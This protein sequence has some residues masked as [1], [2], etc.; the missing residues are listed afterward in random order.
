MELR[1]RFQPE[2]ED[3]VTEISIGDTILPLRLRENPRARRMIL[4]FDRSGEGLVLTL[5]ARASRKRAIAFAQAQEAWILSRMAQKPNRL[6]FRHGAQFPYRG[7]EI[8]IHCTGQTRGTNRLDGDVLFVSGAQDHVSRRVHD[9]LKA[10]AKRELLAASAHYAGK[11]GLQFSRMSL[12][13]T[14]SRWGSCS[15]SGVIS[16]SWRLIFAPSSVLEYVCAHE[17][18]HLR[19]LN[20]G[21]RFWALVRKHFP[22]ID[23]AREWLNKQGAHLHLIG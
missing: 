6:R 7:R 12:R 16:Y 23:P 21:P 3:S 9:W 14:Q 18:A 20:H 11:M 8:T 13:D 17:V 15:P 19:E 22:E 4:R 5:P 1:F 2:P 10:E